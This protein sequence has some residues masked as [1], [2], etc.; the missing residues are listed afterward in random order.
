MGASG[1]RAL[2]EKH[3]KSFGLY[4]AIIKPKALFPITV[5]DETPPVGIFIML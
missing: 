3:I 4:K 2:Q 5:V 1:V